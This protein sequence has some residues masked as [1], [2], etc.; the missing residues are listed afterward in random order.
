[1]NI[2]LVDLDVFFITKVYYCVSAFKRRLQYNKY[3]I[4]LLFISTK[5]MRRAF[6]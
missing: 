1:M 5:F 4:N 6:L 2:N 3:L